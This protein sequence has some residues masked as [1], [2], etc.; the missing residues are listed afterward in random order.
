MACYN[1]W[2]NKSSTK[3]GLLINMS[4]VLIQYVLIVFLG[5]NFNTLNAV[6]IK[7]KVIITSSKDLIANLNSKNT[8]F[9]IKGVVDL[10][11]KKIN[12]PINSELI[13]SKG[14]IINGLVRGNNTKLTVSSTGSIGVLMEGSWLASKIEDVYFNSSILSDDDILSNINCLQ[15]N[16]I[17]NEI[18]LNKHEYNVSIKENNGFVLKLI[19]HT[20]LVNRSLIKLKENNH[21][22]YFIVFVADATDVDI[23]GGCIIG[24]VGKHR[25]INN[26]SSEWGMGIGIIASS[27][28]KVHDITVSR[29]TGDGIYIGG[30]PTNYIGDYSH[31]SK[32]IV[33]RN[34]VSNSN[35]RQ[36]LSVISVDGL[37]VDNCQFINTG[38]IESTPPSAGIDIEPNVS[39]GRNN[40]VRNIVIRN[41]T[42][43]G[44][45]GY[46]FE[47]DLSV[48]DGTVYNYVNVIVDKCQADGQFFIGA[49]NVSVTNSKMESLVI[50]PYEAPMNLRFDGCQIVG[51]GILVSDPHEHKQ[52]YNNKRGRNALLCVLFRNCKI[53]HQT[54]S[55]FNT[56][57]LITID[58][59]PDYVSSVT[60]DSCSL[61]YTKGLFTNNLISNKN[62]VKVMYRKCDMKE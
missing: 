22:G 21:E 17:M 47:A 55:W 36:G 32:N 12:L 40:S 43:K 11:L 28:V 3:R 10:N 9:E 20:K 38:G 33:L 34:V 57:S 50:R 52:L 44:N 42:L 59:K 31:A 4:R 18:Y 2:R 6:G 7:N 46:S 54:N 23:S 51:R 1:V 26:T 24:D 19:N 56:K 5:F 35:R 41:C 30:Y 45:K 53:Y 14:K 27:N 25:Y 62:N 16:D 61:H 49:S 58:S 48:S 15:S 39:D 8:V 13:I 60:F 37:L 29:C